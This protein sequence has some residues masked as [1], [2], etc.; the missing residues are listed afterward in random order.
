MTFPSYVH[1][2][3]LGEYIYIAYCLQVTYDSYMVNAAIIK[4]F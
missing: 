1:N 3:I 2:I 4:Y